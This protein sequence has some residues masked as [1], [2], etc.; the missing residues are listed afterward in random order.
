MN[1]MRCPTIQFEVHTI[2][3]LPMTL[4]TRLAKHQQ[5]RQL[6]LQPQ[7]KHLQIL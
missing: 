2:E 4:L 1:T 5:I 7:L 3:V 6:I